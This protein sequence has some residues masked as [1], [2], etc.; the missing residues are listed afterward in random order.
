MRSGEIPIIAE[1]AR[2]HGV[3]DDDILHAFGNPIWVEEL[4][5]AMLMFV[6]PDQACALVE[7]G[8]VDST[9]GPVVVHAMEARPKYLR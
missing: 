4:D 8:V 5:D 2:K 9:D 3:K 7:I 6:G 1:R